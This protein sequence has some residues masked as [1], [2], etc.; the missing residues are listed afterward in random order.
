MHMTKEKK[1]FWNNKI[2]CHKYGC[3]FCKSRKCCR[4]HPISRQSKHRLYLSQ[5]IWFQER[6][7][8]SCRNL[9]S[10]IYTFYTAREGRKMGRLLYRRCNMSGKVAL[11]NKGSEQD[12]R[13]R[14]S[15]IVV[16]N[17]LPLRHSN[18]PKCQQCRLCM[19][20]QEKDIS[21]RR[22]TGTGSN[23]CI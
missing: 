7:R 14:R 22:K 2:C 18:K 1:H 11:F 6:Y 23:A 15:S 5:N 16:T 3:V 10:F 4:P 12:L 13:E 20:Y 19:Y 21:N 9:H 8:I 17:G